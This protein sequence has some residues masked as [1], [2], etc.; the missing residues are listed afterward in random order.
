MAANSHVYLSVVTSDATIIYYVVLF[1]LLTLLHK[2]RVKLAV[3]KIIGDFGNF[4]SF[5]SFR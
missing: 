1:A 5:C 2:W 4:S 3:T